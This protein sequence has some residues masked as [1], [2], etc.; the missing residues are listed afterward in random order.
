MNL[1]IFQAD[2]L[3]LDLERTRSVCP[4]AHSCSVW[5]CVL[6]DRYVDDQT[7]EKLTRLIALITLAVPALAVVFLGQTA[8]TLGS[9][10]IIR[11]A[12]R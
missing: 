1:A 4:S 5:L 10:S 11:V 2:E 9:A 3:S 8:V 7:G 12:Y 6:L